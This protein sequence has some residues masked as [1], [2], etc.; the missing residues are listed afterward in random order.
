AYLGY[1]TGIP[2]LETAGAVIGSE[3]GRMV[4][5]AVQR[6]KGKSAAIVPE[7]MDATE[8]MPPTRKALPSGPIIT[9]PPADTSGPLPFD[10]AMVPENL[11]GPKP[12][13][14]PSS[15]APEA[16]AAPPRAAKPK[17][18]A[19]NGKPKA[20]ELLQDKM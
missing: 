20:A 19:R 18:E 15:P 10:P 7:V 16:A 17:T 2:G 4:R 13:P 8:V 11:H 1:K 9:P 5:D 12:N 14:R 3:A 6:S